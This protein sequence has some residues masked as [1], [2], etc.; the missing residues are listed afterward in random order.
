MIVLSTASDVIRVATSAANALDAHASFLVNSASGH[1]RGRENTAITTAT[2]TTVVPAPTAGAQRE[3]EN[4]TLNARGG[5]NTVTVELFD[6]TTA[7]RLASVALAAGETLEYED[8][9]GWHVL[10]AVGELKVK[11]S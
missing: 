9:V 3:I 6:G 8:G 4:L 7:Y 10:T 2:T 1:T 11:Q 5:A